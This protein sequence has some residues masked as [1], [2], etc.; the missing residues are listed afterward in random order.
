M[1]YV[2]AAYAVVAGALVAYGIHRAREIRRLRRA[3]GEAGSADR[4]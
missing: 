2:V 1:A 4:H 3:L